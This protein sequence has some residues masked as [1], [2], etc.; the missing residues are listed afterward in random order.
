MPIE[1]ADR[2]KNQGFILWPDAFYT[3]SLGMD[4]D[5]LSECVAEVKRR[6]L[7]GVFGTTPF[8]R[9]QTLDVL[10]ELPQLEAVEFWDV[11][12]KSISALYELRCGP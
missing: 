4:S 1:W 6:Q 2:A 5:R 11:A 10:L 3:P 9:E 12:L 7:K 8:F